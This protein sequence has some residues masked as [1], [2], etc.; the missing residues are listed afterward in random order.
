[1]TLAIGPSYPLVQELEGSMQGRAA[2]AKIF[3]V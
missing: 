2:G 1:M 3:A